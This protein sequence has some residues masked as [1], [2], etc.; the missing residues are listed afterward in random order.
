MKASSPCSKPQNKE[1]YGGNYCAQHDEYDSAAAGFQS[2]VLP[3]MRPRAPN[4]TYDV[5]YYLQFIGAAFEPTPEPASAAL[6]VAGAA[7]CC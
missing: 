3:I 5:G 2:H 7:V 6:F 4:Y 1:D